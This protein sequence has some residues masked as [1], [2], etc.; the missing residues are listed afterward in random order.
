MNKSKALV[1]FAIVILAV[2]A[3]GYYVFSKKSQIIS[4]ESNLGNKGDTSYAGASKGGYLCA[5]CTIAVIYPN[6]GETLQFGSTVKIEWATKP[7]F[8]N[9]KVDIVLHRKD[10]SSTFVIATGI[11]NTGSYSWSTPN[12]RVSTPYVITVSITSLGNRGWNEN[13]NSDVSD[14]PFILTNSSSSSDF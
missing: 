11:S 10:E 9:E 3:S 7:E 13:P 12:V 2:L 4:T 1:I 8:R 5:D 6:G 14:A